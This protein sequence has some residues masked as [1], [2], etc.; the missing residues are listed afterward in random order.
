MQLFQLYSKQLG[1]GEI[2]LASPFLG[3][4]EGGTLEGENA[5]RHRR[6]FLSGI[7]GGGIGVKPQRG[8]G[9]MVDEKKK[10][11]LF[12]TLKRYLFPTT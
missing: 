6:D 2:A 5:L 11:F 4:T 1:K 3:E 9:R 8:G 10:G 12:F 7:R